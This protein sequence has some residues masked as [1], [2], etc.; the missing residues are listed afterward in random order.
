[1]LMS[2]PKL[3]AFRI[4]NI[5]I[6]RTAFFSKLIRKIL[7]DML[8]KKSKNKYFASSNFFDWDDIEDK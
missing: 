3:I 6:G 2:T 7:V 1:M 5:T 8:I 4:Y